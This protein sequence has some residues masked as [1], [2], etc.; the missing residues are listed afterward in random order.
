M[1]SLRESNS[2][3]TP[4]EK[5]GDEVRS[6]ADEVPF[7][8]PDSWEWVRLGELFQHN[9]GK[10]LNASNRTGQLKQYITTSNL[11]WDRFELDNL[12]EMHFSDSEVEKYT[13]PVRR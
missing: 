5:I 6:L 2:D 1:L 9:T 11:Y 4:Y 8:I 13:A 7:D 3:N 10:A 12:K